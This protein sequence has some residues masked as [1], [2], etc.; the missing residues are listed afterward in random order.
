MPPLLPV[1]I[2]PSFLLS[3]HLCTHSCVY[4]SVHLL[5]QWPTPPCSCPSHPACSLSV[6]PSPASIRTP[7]ALLGR[8]TRHLGPPRVGGGFSIRHPWQSSG[9]GRVW[10]PQGCTQSP[11]T[12]AGSWVPKKRMQPWLQG[13]R[14]SRGRM[15][16]QSRVQDVWEPQ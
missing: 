2:H 1:S 7:G 8:P 10:E 13:L 16:P 4:L 14:H 6:S 3:A 9:P 5:V 15:G 12:K 11:P